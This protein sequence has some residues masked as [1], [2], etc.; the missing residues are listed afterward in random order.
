MALTRERA[1]AVIRRRT[2]SLPSALFADDLLIQELSRA[3]WRAASDYAATGEVNEAG[4][5][6]M[7]IERWNIAR[8]AAGVVDPDQVDEA[9]NHPPLFTCEEVLVWPNRDDL[10]NEIARVAE[11]VDTWSEVGPEALRKSGPE[12]DEG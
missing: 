3:E 7:L 5:P 11:E 8:F 12:S 6:V 4:Q 2:K 9:G 10:W 1:A